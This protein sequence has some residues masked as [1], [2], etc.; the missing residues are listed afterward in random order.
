MIR[1]SLSLRLIYLAAGIV[2]LAQTGCSS[3]NSSPLGQ[4]SAEADE[5]STSAIS[6]TAAPDD[7]S[8]NWFRFRG[9]TGDGVTQADLPVN[10]S[11]DENIVWKTPLPG[12]GASSP[13]VWGDRIFL[14]CYTGY[15]TPRQPG[16]SLDELERHVMAFRVSDGELLWDKAV[17][18]KLPEEETIRD[19]GYAANTPAVDE[20]RV[21]VFLGK[22]GVFAFDHDGNQLWQ[23]DVGQNTSGWGTSASPLLYKNLVIIN[24]SVESQSLVALDRETGDE[25]WRTGGIKQAWNTPIVVESP[26]GRSE[27]IVP[28]VKKVLAFDPDTGKPLWSCNTDITWYMVPT[29]VEHDGV[30]YI[31]GGRSGI[32]SLAVKTGGSG[33]VTDSHRLWTSNKG[34]NVSSPI[35]KDGHLYWMNDQRGIAYC[36]KADSGELVYEE[37][38]DRAGQI[39]SS[40]LL[41]GDR[42]YYTNRNGQTFVLAAQPEFEQLAVNNLRDGGQ[43]NGS[44]AVAGD[45][46]LIRSDNYLYCLGN[47]D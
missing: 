34:S 27:L 42:I 22:T 31:L 39:Y 30:L 15:G 19:H 44:P 33:D 14:T 25:V 43:F 18:A 10:W 12:P 4:P 13:V 3:D 26:T 45:R 16:G 38:I 2:C 8:A 47:Q 37:R 32:T 20:D 1:P 5:P 9:P 28:I 29:V 21:Y 6:T 11:Q 7:R 46:L 24:A 17:P 36:A 40:P 23:A 41:A 35:Y